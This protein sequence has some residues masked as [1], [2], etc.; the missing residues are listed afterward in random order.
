MCKKMSIPSYMF[1]T[2]VF[3]HI[4]DH[5]I[6]I[7]VFRGK[8]RFYATHVQYDEI[9]N[10]ED[11]KRREELLEVFNDVIER[12]VS[13]GSAVW[14]VSN[15]DQAKWSDEENGLYSDI[16]TKLDKLNKKKKNNMQDALIAETAIKNHFV[17]VT[18]D[19]DL[20]EVTKIFGGK[21]TD[22]PTVFRC[23]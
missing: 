16:K 8:A 7:S 13:T 21:C 17:L 9:K 14:D 3:N 23:R 15:W 20:R 6:D 11:P 4:L 2:T 19:K 18:D 1:D 12:K 22:S 10:T 5:G